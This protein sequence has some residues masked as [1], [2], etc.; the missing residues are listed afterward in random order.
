MPSFLG[1]LPAAHPFASFITACPPPAL[2][3]G[4][5]ATGAIAES[6]R[7]TASGIGLEPHPKPLEV[8]EPRRVDRV[9]QVHA[10]LEQVEQHLQVALRLDRAPITP[11]ASHGSW[12]PSG[13]A[14]SRTRES[15]CGT[16]ACSAP[17]CWEAPPAS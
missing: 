5:G 12:A 3:G 4:S 10:E 2:P 17:P 13:P 8:P 15:G 6:A 16:G 9:L 7:R 14:G 11:K 1:S